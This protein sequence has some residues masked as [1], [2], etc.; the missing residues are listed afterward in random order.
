MYLY[1]IVCFNLKQ[2]TDR[3]GRFPQNVMI[4]T[5]KINKERK[6]LDYP[7]LY[8]IIKKICTQT[9]SIYIHDDDECLKFLNFDFIH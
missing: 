5:S 2:Y 1:R 6:P 3:P 9:E 7:I 8:Y 4:I